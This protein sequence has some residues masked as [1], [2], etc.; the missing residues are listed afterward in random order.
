MFGSIPTFKASPAN[1]CLFRKLN[2]ISEPMGSAY[3]APA[4]HH[5]QESNDKAANATKLY[6]KSMIV[7]S[8][9]FESDEDH[10]DANNNRD[11]DQQDSCEHEQHPHVDQEAEAVPIPA[12]YCCELMC[13]SAV[14]PIDDRVTMFAF[15]VA[16]MPTS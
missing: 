14:Q 8:P 13:H 7:I 2:A 5:Q 15:E 12:F 10:D 9:A 3:H 11:T 1:A 4:N 16:A 6:N